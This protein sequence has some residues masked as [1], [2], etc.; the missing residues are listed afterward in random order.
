VGN[1][2]TSLSRMD[3]SWK[4]KL[5]IDAVKLI[6]VMNQMDLT[7]IYR[8]FHP[9]TKEYIFSSAPYDTFSKINN[10]IGHKAGFNRYKKL[11]VMPCILSDHHRLRLVFN[12][13]TKQNKNKTKQNKTPKPKEKTQNKQTNKKQKHQKSH[14]HM[15]AEQSSS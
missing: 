13:K 1:F 10:M 4:Q 5:N 15:E 12:G 2:T 11:K 3:R 9:K 7:D 14:I 8:T 6:E